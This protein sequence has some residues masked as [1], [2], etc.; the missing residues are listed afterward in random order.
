MPTLRLDK[1][2]TGSGLYSRR[3]AGN[4]IKDGRVTVGGQV[5]LSKEEKFNSDMELICIDGVPVEYRTYRYFM[6]NKPKGVL[7]ATIDR[8]VETV[9]D[10]LKPEHSRLGL[11]P[12][13]R[14]D[15]DVTGLL[16]LTND[17]GFAHKV[18]SP[19][20]GIGKTYL[21]LTDIAVT[22]ADV[23]AFSGGIML[24][25][26]TKS[27]PASL[28]PVQGGA[29]ITLREGKFHQVKRMMEAIGKPVIDLSR[30]SVG[31]LVLDEGLRPGEYY[32]LSN[33]EVSLIFNNPETK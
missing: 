1:I 10:I 18:M 31:G 9:L 14:L 32:E 13:G 23:C 6:M 24:S 25:D 30:V 16:L 8:S 29:Y 2:L 15:K 4:L 12:V 28:R 21:A 19:A 26:G 11:F 7:S 5:V 20:G 3:E 22:A 27:L 33:E 17:G